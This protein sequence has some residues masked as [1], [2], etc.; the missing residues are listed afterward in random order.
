MRR[1]GTHKVYETFSDAAAPDVS[2]RP[3]RRKKRPAPF[4]L[5]L[6]YQERARLDAAAGNLPLSAYIKGRLFEDFP[7][8]PGQR[9]ASKIDRALLT[10]LLGAL[11]QSRLSANMNQIAKAAN[12]G[13]LSVTPELENDLKVACND[14]AAMRRNLLAQS[15][16][17]ESLSHDP[18]WQFQ[19]ERE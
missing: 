17:P 15:T 12:T 13:S 10:K 5:R 14:I 9:P 1:P 7:T 2:I 16:R 3:T 6:T 11:G 18:A 4:S 19:R 8:V